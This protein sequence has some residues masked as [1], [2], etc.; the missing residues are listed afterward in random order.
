MDGS[1]PTDAAA[2]A[3]EGGVVPFAFLNTVGPTL[4]FLLIAAAILCANGMR[5]C[6]CGGDSRPSSAEEEMVEL[7]QRGVGTVGGLAVGKRRVIDSN[8]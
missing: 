8:G 1:A 2:A 3:I 4:E 7:I 5:L 6:E